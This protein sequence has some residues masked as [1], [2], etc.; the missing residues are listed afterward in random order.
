MVAMPIYD[1]TLKSSSPELRKLLSWILVYSIGDSKSSI[2]SNND[3]RMTLTF[4]Q[5]GQIYVPVAVAILEEVARYLQICNSCFYKVCKSL[6]M[7][8]G[9]SDHLQRHVWPFTL[10]AG[11]TSIQFYGLFIPWPKGSRDIAI[12]LASLCLS[13]RPSVDK[14]LCGP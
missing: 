9:M 8:N 3:A 14:A 10:S 5:Y 2:C 7:G 12:A 13:V 1:K 11:S 6:L 4:L